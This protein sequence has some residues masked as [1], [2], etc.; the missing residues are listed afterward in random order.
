MLIKRGPVINVRRWRESTRVVVSH[1]GVAVRFRST[2][3]ILVIVYPGRV[4][5]AV[6]H[7]RVASR[8]SSPSSVSHIG[9]VVQLLLARGSTVRAGLLVFRLLLSKH[10][11][12]LRLPLRLFEFDG[13][14]SVESGDLSGHDLPL[15]LSLRVTLNINTTFLKRRARVPYHSL[16][17]QTEFG[18]LS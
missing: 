14:T 5:V 10:R 12:V 16:D 8:S 1:P 9:P 15:S 6:L 17:F 3:I 7:V 18:L 2:R 13:R 11:L 4:P